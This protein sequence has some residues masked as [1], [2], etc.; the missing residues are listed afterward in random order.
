VAGDREKLD[1]DALRAADA[2]RQYVAE[3]LREALNEGRLDLSEYD[4]RVQQ[5]YGARTYGDLKGLL[6]DLPDTVPLSRSQVAPAFPSMAPPAPPR[7]LTGQWLAAQWGQWLTLS[8]IMSAIWL[9]SGA[10]YF[11]PI[12]VIAPVGAIKLA[13]T[14][15][16]LGG[17]EPRKQWEKKIRKEAEREAER[18]ASRQRKQARDSDH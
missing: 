3:R 17:G 10:G 15:A 4:D 8:L 14:L 2:D 5:A 12:W 11:W 18:D 6:S 13:Q 16:G 1:R 9:V 7:N